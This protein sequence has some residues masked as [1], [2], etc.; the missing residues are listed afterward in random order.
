MPAIDGRSG[1]LG[2]IPGV[3]R[4]AGA[5]PEDVAGELTGRAA[6]GAVGSVEGVGVEGGVTAVSAINSGSA[7]GGGVGAMRVPVGKVGRALLPD[8][9]PV[10]E[11][12]R[13]EPFARPPLRP[14]LLPDP[15]LFVDG[16]LMSLL[17]C[18][19][20]KRGAQA[21]RIRHGRWKPRR[22]GRLVNDLQGA[23]SSLGAL[24]KVAA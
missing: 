1:V 7:A 13:P 9:P 12:D 22:A 15:E 16:V 17:L 18:G 23:N 2:R 14:L 24:L 10:A 20:G 4:V 11:V 3:E 8:R 19:C 21:P 5:A 6:A